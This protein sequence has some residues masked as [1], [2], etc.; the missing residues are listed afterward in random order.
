MPLEIEVLT[1]LE[2]NFIYAIYDPETKTSGVVDP[3]DADVVLKFLKSKDRKLD[4]VLN[5]HHH[6]D[7]TA[8]NSILRREARCKILGSHFDRDRIP[9]LSL[10]LSDG[11]EFKF[12]SLNV[13]VLGMP[14]HTLGAIAYY[15]EEEHILFTGDTLFSFGCGRLFEG[16]S[17]QMFESLQTLK[18]LPDGTQVYFGHEYTEKNLKFA[19]YLEPGRVDLKR[20]WMRTSKLRNE[21]QPTTPS[22][23][24]VQKKMNPFLN[25]DLREFVRIRKLRDCF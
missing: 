16:T 10:S 4:F 11:S 23:L 24:G 19:M 2:D 18:A 5:T 15:F 13:Q 8:G 22:R 21:K 1:A 17:E 7:H 3:S 14:G 12:G 9:E 25:C 20:E 6:W